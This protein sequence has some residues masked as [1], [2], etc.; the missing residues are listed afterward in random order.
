VKLRSILTR[1]SYC[2][3]LLLA[4]Q[5]HSA[6]VTITGGELDFPGHETLTCFELKIGA[7]GSGQWQPIVS[8]SC[9]I[10]KDPQVLFIDKDTGYLFSPVANESLSRR[11]QD[12][13]CVVLGNGFGTG[14]DQAPSHD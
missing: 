12:L 11:C 10:S 6:T 3:P 5:A 9:D 14:G 8:N 13:G 4:G 2:V 1:L 7:D